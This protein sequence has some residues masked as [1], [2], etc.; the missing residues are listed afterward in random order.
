MVCLPQNRHVAAINFRAR[1]FVH[2]SATLTSMAPLVYEARECSY[3][4]IP[5]SAA[6]GRE[7]PSIRA[8]PY[9]RVVLKQMR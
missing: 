9:A 4:E 8:A 1:N 5:L 6:S 7:G 2:G 3:T